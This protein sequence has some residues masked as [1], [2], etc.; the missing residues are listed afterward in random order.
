MAIHEGRWDCPSCQTQGLLGRDRECNQCGAPRPEGVRFY[1][2][3]DA[4][5]V[6]NPAQI[7]VAKAGADW[8]CEYCGSSNRTTQSQCVECGAPQSQVTQAVRDYRL[9]EVPRSGERT[10]SQP[11]SI[12]LPPVSRLQSPPPRRKLGAIGICLAIAI[13]IGV[14]LFQPISLDATVSGLS[15]ERTVKIERLT[16]VTESDWS[17]PTGGRILSQ[18]EEIRRYEQVIDR[19][20]TR[21][22][23]VS[24]QVQVGTE[25]Y[26]C[27][28]RDLGN[29]FFE[30]K[31][32]TRAIYETRTRTETY[33]EPIYRDEPVYDTKY[34]YEID[35]WLPDREA[36]ATGEEKSAYWPEFT[37]ETDEREAQRTE[38]YQ[39]RFLD[40]K[41]KTYTLKMEEETWNG[42]AVGESRELKVNRLGRVKLAQD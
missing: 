1:L 10:P 29:G 4:Q 22:R 13:G 25:S 39:V 9:N 3:K 5:P 23:D 31:T 12:S 17:V 20:E 2:P 37:L 24:E 8:I 11:V 32:C 36:V 40:E 26:V 27:G 21:T 19:Y 6:K 18:E 35:K 38:K 15:W 33:E 28:T 34:T 41:G 30:D 42:F 7:A 14:F 16:T